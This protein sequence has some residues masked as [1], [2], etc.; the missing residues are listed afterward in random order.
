MTFSSFLSDAFHS[1]KMLCDQYYL[2]SPDLIL[3]EM[4]SKIHFKIGFTRNAT[5]PEMGGGGSPRGLL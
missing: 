4:N 5:H 1:A 3:Q 2:T